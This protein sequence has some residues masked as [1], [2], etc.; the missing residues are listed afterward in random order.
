[1]E[2]GG[3]VQV[4]NSKYKILNYTFYLEYYNSFIYW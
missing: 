1:M 4:T 2:E 3:G